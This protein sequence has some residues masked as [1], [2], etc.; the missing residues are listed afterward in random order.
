MLA[1]RKR[2]AAVGG[3]GG[4]GPQARRPGRP[5]GGGRTTARARAPTTT[6]P[7]ARPTRS[8]WSRRPSDWRSDCSQFVA[9]VYKEAGLPSPATV[10]HE[11][12][13]TSNI[14]PKGRVTTSP[15]PGDLA[16][17]GTHG[18]FTHHVELYCGAPG[19][20]FIGHGSAPIDSA[21]PGRPDY[22]LTYDFLG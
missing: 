22:Y 7:A 17:Y 3:A 14:D 13:A 12:A 11:F 15:R 18:G 1:A 19:Q 4:R 2:R 9:A 8:A 10:A 20:E 16:M 5:A 6:W 21:T